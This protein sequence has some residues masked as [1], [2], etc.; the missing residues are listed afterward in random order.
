MTAF[1][2]G[3]SG[4]NHD[5]NVGRSRCAA[6]AE[7]EVAIQDEEEGHN[8]GGDLHEVYHG[9]DALKSGCAGGLGVIE[10]V[11]GCFRFSGSDDILEVMLINGAVWK[12]SGLAG[13]ND[14]A[15]GDHEYQKGAI[16]E[17]A[18]REAFLGGGV[19]LAH[20]G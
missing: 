20:L 5:R 3:G 14:E 19:A 8:D 15:G 16:A 7:E 11:P 6:E 18:V 1:V 4:P 17:E 12:V 2:G 9:D 13:V 10:G